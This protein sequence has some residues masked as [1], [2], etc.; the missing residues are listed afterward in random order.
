MK[1]RVKQGKQRKQR[2]QRKLQVIE[3]STTL[4]R[5]EAEKLFSTLVEILELAKIENASILKEESAHEQK[6]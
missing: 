5:K 1:S 4:S 2:K 3:I 6:A